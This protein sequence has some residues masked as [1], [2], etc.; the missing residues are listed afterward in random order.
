MDQANLLVGCYMES[1]HDFFLLLTRQSLLM[2][3]EDPAETFEQSRTVIN[4]V[5]AVAAKFSH[6]VHAP[7]RGDDGDHLVHHIHAL[8]LSPVI[9]SILVV[10]G[11][12]RIQIIGISITWQR[13]LEETAPLNHEINQWYHFLPTQHR[14][15]LGTDQRDYQPTRERIILG[16]CYYNSK[17]LLN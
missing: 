12:E 4:L 10:P 6:L 9:D 7:W 16:F 3:S 14:L 15:I 1:V 5:F 17:M 11:L 2:Q 8:K 13:F